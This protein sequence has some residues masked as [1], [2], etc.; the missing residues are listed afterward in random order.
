MLCFLRL[1]KPLQFQQGNA[2]IH[3]AQITTQWF[4]KQAIDI[5]SRLARS[6]DLNLIE[7][8]W[9]NLA[10]KVYEGGRQCYSTREVKKIYTGC[11]GLQ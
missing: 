8:L 4:Q 11:Q 6:S 2:T 5:M 1:K 10:R 7:N 9:D 3:Q